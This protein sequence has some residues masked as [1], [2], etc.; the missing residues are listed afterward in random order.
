M[1]SRGSYSMV[2]K[3]YDGGANYSNL[4]FYRGLSREVKPLFNTRL[5]I[6][7]FEQLGKTTGSPVVAFFSDSDSNRDKILDK[8]DLQKLAVWMPGWEKPLVLDAAGKS[9]LAVLRN[10]KDF[11]VLSFGEDRD[12]D[13]AF[14]FEHE[15]VVFYRLNFNCGEPSCIDFQQI[16]QDSTIAKLQKTL[17][18]L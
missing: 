18:G 11:A 6:S 16:V 17:D 10:V 8:H 14:E 2:K 5:S 4:V 9:V 7:Y 3:G 13:G 12:K 1:F 15:P